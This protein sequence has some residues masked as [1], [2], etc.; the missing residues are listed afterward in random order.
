MWMYTGV[1]VLTYSVR[2]CPSVVY[3]C[4]YVCRYMTLSVH[5]CRGRWCIY[6]GPHTIALAAMQRESQAEAANT[7]CWEESSYRVLARGRCVCVCSRN[8][9]MLGGGG[10][11][12]KEKET[13][14][15]MRATKT[16]KRRKQQCQ[17]MLC[18]WRESARRRKRGRRASK[19]IWSEERW[20]L[21]E[22]KVRKGAKDRNRWKWRDRNGE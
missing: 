9:Q 12:T 18:S 4:A 11:K 14:G 22:R 19:W 15:T 6:F 10:V 20:R 8:T 3:L 21:R 5:L 16:E 2:R 7:S 17:K 13:E 1:V